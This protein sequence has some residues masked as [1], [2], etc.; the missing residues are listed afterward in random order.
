[1]T[2]LYPTSYGNESDT[3]YAVLRLDDDGTA[4]FRCQDL[5]HAEVLSDTFWCR[6][7]R[8]LS[9]GQSVRGWLDFHPSESL[10]KG[11]VPGFT[12]RTRP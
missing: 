1:M 6:P 4:Q 11:C 3:V 9:V 10:A 8:S 7:D 12:V 2:L 5:R